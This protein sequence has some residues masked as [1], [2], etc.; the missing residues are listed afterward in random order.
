[1]RF[2][3]RRSPPDAEKNDERTDRPSWIHPN[4]WKLATSPESVDSD[5]NSAQNDRP[6]VFTRAFRRIFL[7]KSEAPISEIKYPVEPPKRGG[8]TYSAAESRQASAKLWSIYVVEAER[9][10]KALVESWKAD[11]EG[12]LIFSGLFSA[13]LTAFL[14]ESYKTLQPDSSAVTIQLLTQ[15]SQQ[16]A[17][18]AAPVSLDGPDFQPTASSLVCNTLW[19]ISLTLSITCALLATLVEQWAREFLHRT[20]SH[21]SPIRRAR[22][23]SFLYFGLRRFG[24]HSMVDL[25][26]LLLHVSLVL[27]FAGLVAFLVPINHFMMALIGSILAGFLSIYAILTILPIVRLDCPFRT[28][29]SGVLWNLIHTLP[30][31]IFTDRVVSS[32]SPTMNDAMVEIALQSSESRD[33]R[34]IGWTL[35]SLTDDTEFIAFLDVIPET[36]FGAGGFHRRNDYLFL[37]PLDNPA[38]PYSVLAEPANPQSLSERITDFILSCQNM[39]ADDPLRQRRLLVAMKAIWALG[40]ISDL[41][42]YRKSTGGGFWFLERTALAVLPLSRREGWPLPYA[43]LAT[44]AIDYARLNNVRSH[45]NSVSCLTDPH[46]LLKGIKHVCSMARVLSLRSGIFKNYIKQLLVWSK[47]S[48][49]MEPEKLANVKRILRRLVE[50]VSWVEE[51]SVTIAAWLLYCIAPVLCDAGPLVQ[52]VTQSCLRMVPTM[53]TTHYVPLDKRMS[54]S[55]YLSFPSGAFDPSRHPTP[56]G[57]I[58]DLDHIMKALIDLLPQLLPKDV[59]PILVSYLS[60]RNDY[61]VLHFVVPTAFHLGHASECLIM[62]L[63]PNHEDEH[64]LLALSAIVVLPQYPLTSWNDYDERLWKYMVEADTFA[65]A[66]FVTLCGV[67]TMR[68]YGDIQ[69]SA[70]KQAKSDFSGGPSAHTTFRELSNRLLLPEKGAFFSP[71]ELVSDLESRVMQAK[72][73]V[74]TDFLAKCPQ[75]VGLRPMDMRHGCRALFRLL[76]ARLDG[77]DIHVVSKFCQIWDA[78]VHHLSENPTDDELHFVFQLILQWAETYTSYLCNPAIAHRLKATLLIYLGFLEMQAIH[79]RLTVERPKRMLAALDAAIG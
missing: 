11:M 48:T 47:E 4:V 35:E 68:K 23:F 41:S 33:Q 32:P 5:T 50:D 10:D 49:K 37:L 30:A 13:S 27:F 20:E 22:V 55:V 31:H 58:S 59:G 9:Y 74:V 15:I 3:S 65:A 54:R 76:D 40:M 42:P 1:M 8:P 66:S 79:D 67:M 51:V 73:V 21:P 38:N 18:P 29:F 14:V 53:G 25:I 36:L 45:I 34:A 46:E 2:W 12:M 7:H 6:S 24:M 16:L 72:V 64:I 77:V 52:T 69:S 56:S 26:P 62:M 44:A 71:E 17:T 19:F 57:Q 28:P 60:K 39:A 75:P 63:E 78:V 70:R 43:Y 61:D